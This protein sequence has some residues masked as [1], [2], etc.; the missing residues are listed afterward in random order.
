MSLLDTTLNDITERKAREY[1]SWIDSNAKKLLSKWQVFLIENSRTP[2]L[3]TKLVAKTADIEIVV[4]ELVGNFGR[5]VV[6]KQHGQVNARR[7]FL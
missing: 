7:K 4:Y 5:E 6:I 1:S 3:L 2:S